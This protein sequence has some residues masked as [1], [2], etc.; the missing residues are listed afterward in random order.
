VP[1]S[2][3]ND[4]R[5]RGNS[6]SRPAQDATKVVG[7]CFRDVNNVPFAVLRRGSRIQACGIDMHK[8]IELN[9]R[10]YG[11]EASIPGDRAVS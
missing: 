11:T 5:A 8:A 3:K 7:M 6:A 9:C 2:K 1:K 4:R 10:R